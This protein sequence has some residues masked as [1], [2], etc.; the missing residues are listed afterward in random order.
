MSLTSNRDIQCLN[1]SHNLI[2]FVPQNLFSNLVS[3]QK[4]DLSHNH[5]HDFDF[6]VSG[7]ISLVNLNL[8]DNMISEIS[9]ATRKQ[10][11]Q[12]AEHIAPQELSLL[13]CLTINW[14]AYV[15]TSL[16]FPL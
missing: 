6:N 14:L 1:F 12:L 9:E 4:L 2:N 3:L 10:L 5:I 7:L 15:Q 16:P 13:T 11:I 8:E